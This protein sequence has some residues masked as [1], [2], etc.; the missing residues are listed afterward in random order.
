MKNKFSKYSSIQQPCPI[1]WNTMQSIEDSNDRFCQHCKKEVKDISNLSEAEIRNSLSK[2]DLC[3]RATTEQVNVPL[4]SIRKLGKVGVLLFGL[5]TGHQS[6]AQ[7]F[8]DKPVYSFEQTELKSDTVLLKGIIKGERK[9][10]IRQLR[11]ERIVGYK[12]LQNVTISVLSEEGLLI[13]G[14]YPDKNGKFEIPV[15]R[16]LLGEYFTIIIDNKGDEDYATARVSKLEAK[17]TNFEF[18]LTERVF[19]IGRLL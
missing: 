11:M 14:A 17:N 3:V 1:D 15:D 5:F 9:L 16:R 6:S 19:V 13:V 8:P 2:G 4:R 12:Q 18:F 10:R 7:I